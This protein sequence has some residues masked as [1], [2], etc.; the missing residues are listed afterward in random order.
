M[1]PK[2][3]TRVPKLAINRGTFDPIPAGIFL[4]DDDKQKHQ[5][6][7]R[8]EGG[9]RETDSKKNFVVPFLQL[10]NLLNLFLFIYDKIVTITPMTKSQWILVV[11]ALFKPTLDTIPPDVKKELDELIGMIKEKLTPTPTEHKDKDTPT[12]HKDK[13]TPTEHKD[14]DTPTEHKDKDKAGTSTSESASQSKSKTPVPATVVMDKEIEMLQKYREPDNA[15]SYYN[16]IDFTQLVRETTIPSKRGPPKPI[17]EL[18]EEV[19]KESLTSFVISLQNIIIAVAKFFYQ[20]H[21]ELLLPIKEEIG[22]PNSNSNQYPKHFKLHSQFETNLTLVFLYGDTEEEDYI[23]FCKKIPSLEELNNQID[24]EYISV[25]NILCKMGNIIM[26]PLRGTTEIPTNVRVLIE[27]LREHI[28]N[29]ELLGLIDGV[30]LLYLGML[31]GLFLMKMFPLKPSAHAH[32][33]Q[34]DGTEWWKINAM[35]SRELLKSIVSGAFYT[36]GSMVMS[37]SNVPKLDLNEG[38]TE[39]ETETEMDWIEALEETR[40]KPNSINHEESTSLIFKMLS[41][42]TT[43]FSP[44]I[45]LWLFEKTKPSRFDLENEPIALLLRSNVLTNDKNGGSDRDGSS[46][47]RT[48][49]D[50]LV[51]PTE[52]KSNAMA[53]YNKI[54]WSSGEY[55]E[56]SKL[57]ALSEGPQNMIVL[58]LAK[59]KSGFIHRN[60]FTNKLLLEWI[61]TIKSTSG[62]GNGTTVESDPRDRTS[63]AF[64]KTALVF[65]NRKI[66]AHQKF[67]TGPF[68]F[69]HE[70]NMKTDLALVRD[71]SVET[72]GT[73]MILLPFLF[74]LQNQYLMGLFDRYFYSLLK[75][76]QESYDQ[77]TNYS[78]T[79]FKYL[80]TTMADKGKLITKYIQNGSIN[81]ELGTGSLGVEIIIKEEPVDGEENTTKRDI[82]VFLFDPANA[83]TQIPN[84]N[85]TIL[86]NPTTNTSFLSIT[87]PTIL[88]LQI[89][90]SQS[91]RISSLKLTKIQILIPQQFLLNKRLII[92]LL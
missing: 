73:S 24:K 20:V 36:S 1:I 54:L 92:C 21:K 76:V 7:N 88:Y 8:Q 26:T 5:V 29:T 52:W 47:H 6:R 40:D 13:D 75:K 86:S 46:A 34:Q 58:D 53:Y 23:N 74:P 3:Q 56:L 85:K 33:Q 66:Q 51:K 35:P 27:P 28:Q 78:S 89:K 84:P 9:Q 64:P 72:D 18:V 63:P 68:F 42:I 79:L 4:I 91:L 2:A 90:S 44:K 61:E 16:A 65:M 38:E 12:E 82:T 48:T 43:L 25:C 59:E 71:P 69:S 39:T 49:F 70:C 62:S 80:E 30:P 32:A 41:E 10:A 55:Y 67:Q 60:V 15:P 45:P 50:T 81:N 37:H 22:N 57:I 11:I 83:I 14:K 77:Y 19:T 31:R 17:I 87:R